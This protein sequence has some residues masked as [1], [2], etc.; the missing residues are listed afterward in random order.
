[1]QQS[2]IRSPRED[3]FE[4]WASVYRAYLDFYQTSLSQQELEKVWSWLMEENSSMHCYVAEVNNIIAGLTHFRP[5]IRPVKASKAIFLDDLIVLPE[6]RGQ[7]IGNQLIDAVK[8]Y[9]KNHGLLLV[10]WI[11]A[12]DNAQAMKLYDSVANKTAWVTYDAL[13]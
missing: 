5:F 8:N 9:A 13:I 11:T 6:F 2:L 1:M 10:R 12:S 3:E 7:G 4:I